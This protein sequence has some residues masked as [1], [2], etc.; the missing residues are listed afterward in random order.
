LRGHQLYGLAFR[1]QHPIGFFIVD[2]CCVA[3]KLVIE[4]DG[5]SHAEQAEYDQ[6]RTTWLADRGYKVIRFTNEQIN[7]QIEEALV[8]IARWCGEPT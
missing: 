5:H 4:I 6:E 7:H 8:E 1:R 3:R 2:L